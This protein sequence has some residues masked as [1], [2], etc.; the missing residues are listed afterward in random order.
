MRAALHLAD[1]VA[2]SQPRRAL[3]ALA[4]A[5][6][7]APFHAPTLEAMARLQAALGKSEQALGSYRAALSASPQFGRVATRLGQLYDE[8]KE[9]GLAAIMFEHAA[10]LAP[11]DADAQVDVAEHLLAQG[12][13]TKASEACVRALQ[14]DGQNARGRALLARLI[15]P[16]EQL[17]RV[18]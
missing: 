3:T 4:R 5:H 17:V 2:S 8:R 10:G 7:Y 11:N 15:A 1:V 9:S 14:L 16:M 13:V 6:E 18:A 12:E